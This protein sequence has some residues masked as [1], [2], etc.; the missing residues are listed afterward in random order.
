MHLSSQPK[1]FDAIAAA[2]ERPDL[3]RDERFATRELRLRNYSAL[4]GV[5][6]EIVATRP[7]DHW[8]RV[9]EEH[10]VPVGA[11]HDVAEVFDDPQVRHLDTFYRQRHPTEGEIIAVHRPVLID[12]GR[13]ERALAAPTLGEHTAEILAE[14]GYGGEE[15]EK[16]RKAAAI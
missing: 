5:I 4:N 14:L 9:L 13:E 16:L 10:D 1:F 11:G 12:G 6:G 15:I 2:L 7:R 8:L 3:L